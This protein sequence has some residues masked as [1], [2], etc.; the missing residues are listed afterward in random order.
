MNGRSERGVLSRQGAW[1]QVL[2][3]NIVAALVL[4]SIVC[5][6]AAYL[7]AD[8]NGDLLYYHYS[9]GYFFATGHLIRDSLANLGSYQDPTI[10]GAEYF[11]ISRMSPIVATLIVAGVQSLSIYCLFALTMAVFK[12]DTNEDRIG[13]LAVAS[14]VSLSAV[15]GPVFWSEIGSTMNDVLLSG[16]TLIAVQL[17]AKTVD[18]RNEIRIRSF[19]AMLSGLLIGA[20]SGFKFTNMEYALAVPLA[21][22][23][24]MAFSRTPFR[25]AAR[26]IIVFSAGSG[27][28]FVVVYGFV[29]WELWEHFRN[30]IFPYFNAVFQSPDFAMD[31]FHDGRWFPQNFWAYIA[32]PFRYC[33][34]TAFKTQRPYLFGMEIPFHTAMYGA[35]FAL[36][37][38]YAIAEFR[39][40]RMSAPAESDYARM[41][42]VAFF[43]VAYAIWEK[44][45]AYYRFMATLEIMAPLVV[46]IMLSRVSWLRGRSAHG[47]AY[48]SAIIIAIASFSFPH[49]TWGR[50]PFTKTYFGTGVRALAKYRNALIVVNSNRNVAYAL[51][52]FGK[53]DRFVGLLQ[54]WLRY[55]PRFKRRYFARAQKF[56]GP[57]YFLTTYDNR[58]E[59]VRKHAAEIQKAIGR[60]IAIDSCVEV[61][62]HFTPLALCALSGGR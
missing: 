24:V 31:N 34:P 59:I 37:P 46:T 44:E 10:N 52:Y 5:G 27:I 33:D 49:S 55:T 12:R 8:V 60:R 26:L 3:I 48:L 15:F 30:P 56:S 57:A 20:V 45:F 13:S 51:P 19:R 28:A 21:M 47:Y 14:A 4:C 7:G 11:L 2:P 32:M 17:L 16:P 40:F 41:F 53:G 25:E 9:T 22:G 50:E 42:V 39:R 35:A 6:I 62:T 1:G 36:L 23:A 43:F 29:G 58:L 61:K 18:C 54:G 38:V